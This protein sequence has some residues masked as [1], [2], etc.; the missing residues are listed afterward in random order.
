MKLMVFKGPGPTK[1][2]AL[3][4]DQTVTFIKDIPLEVEDEFAK[5]L[6]LDHS[7]VMLFEEVSGKA[8]AKAS[9]AKQVGVEEDI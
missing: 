1:E 3:A 2:F 9:T 4:N 8:R 7:P 6:L 5:Y